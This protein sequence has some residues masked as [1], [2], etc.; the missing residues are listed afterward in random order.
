MYS[1]PSDIERLKIS[2]VAKAMLMVLQRE[3]KGRKRKVPSGALAYILKERFPEI[4]ESYSSVDTMKGWL[5]NVG[6]MLVRKGLIK[7]E[8]NYVWSFWTEE[9]T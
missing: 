7:G 5:S 3:Y 6:K 8:R 4:F 2:E 9:K 1:F